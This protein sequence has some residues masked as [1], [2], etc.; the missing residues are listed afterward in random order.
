MNAR[1]EMKSVGK[2][3]V[4]SQ[5]ASRLEAIAQSGIKSTQFLH[6]PFGRDATRQ[7]EKAAKRLMIETADETIPRNGETYMQRWYLKREANGQRYVHR[8]VKDDDDAPH[9]HPWDSGGWVLAGTL[10]EEWWNDGES[11]LSGKTPNIEILTPGTIALRP[12][13]HIHRLRIE[14]QYK[15]VVTM[16]CTGAKKEEWGFWTPGQWVH[17]REYTKDAQK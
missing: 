17:W 9:D 15:N 6:E 8:M 10:I 7:A 2:I 13:H 16:F 5:Y 4:L 1:S 11:A 14:P 3:E 12:A